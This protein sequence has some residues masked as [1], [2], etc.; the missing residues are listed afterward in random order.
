M[1][2]RCSSGN[3]QCQRGDPVPDRPCVRWKI[4]VLAFFVRIYSKQGLD[5]S[6]RT[7]LQAAIRAFTRAASTRHE[8]F[9]ASSA[10]H[11]ATASPSKS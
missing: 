3:M 6:R 8:A 11:F 9:A 10:F 4:L 2:Y 1:A 5:C 7:L